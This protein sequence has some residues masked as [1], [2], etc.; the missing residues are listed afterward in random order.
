MFLLTEYSTSDSRAP[1]IQSIG[2]DS[3][4]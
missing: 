1:A 2:M 3:Y 4:K